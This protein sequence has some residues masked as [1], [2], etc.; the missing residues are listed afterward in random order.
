MLLLGLRKPGHKAPTKYSCLY[1]V[2]QASFQFKC[3]DQVYPFMP[4]VVCDRCRLSS[5]APRISQGAFGLKTHFILVKNP[6]ACFDFLPINLRQCFLNPH[7]TLFAVPFYQCGLR[8]V[9]TQAQV[10]Q[11]LG[12][13]A[14]ADGI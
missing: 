8:L 2:K 4:S 7:T 9:K 1:T 14:I 10:F 12:Q 3:A 11:Q 6:S 5:N 13:I